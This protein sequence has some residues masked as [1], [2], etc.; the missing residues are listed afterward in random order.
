MP[1]I[2]INITDVATEAKQ[3]AQITEASTLN[4]NVGAKADAAASTDTGSFS[5]IAFIKR[6][7][8]NWTTLLGKIPNQVGGKIPVEV[9]TVTVTGGLTDAQLRATPVPVSGTVTAN[10]GLNPLTD[11][12]IRATPLPISG[13]VTA[14]TGLSQPLTDAQLRSTP[15]PISGTVT[16]NTGLTQPITDAQIRATPLPISGTVDTGLTQP[17]TNTELRAAPVDIH[18]NGAEFTFSTVNSTADN[19]AVGASFAGAVESVLTF[20]AI[21]LLFRADQT[22]I[23]TVTQYEDAGGLI[24]VNQPTQYI[25]YA[26]QPIARSFPINGNYI[27]VSVKNVGVATTTSLTLDTAYGVIDSATQLNNNSV[28]L[29]EVAGN[30]T[31]DIFRTTFSNVI[32]S[33]V[34]PS[35]FDI[36]RS[37]GTGQTVA[38]SAGNLVLT[39]G[40]TANSETILRSVRSFNGSMIARMQT[41]LSQRIAQNNF[42]FELVDVVG[43]GLTA[44][45]NSATSITVTIPNSPFT[46]A[47]VG[48]GMYLGAYSGTGTFAPQRGVIASVSGNNVTYT[49]AGMAAG[50]GTCSVFGWNY[51]QS[52]YTGITATNI[53]YGTQ[54]RGWTD[55]ASTLQINTTTTVGHMAIM[56]ND[57]GNAYF[58]D[59]LVATN[60]FIQTLNRGSR[61]MNLPEENTQLFLQIRMANGTSAPA[62]N[63]TWTVGM[64][65]V[66][67]YSPVPMTVNNI[68]PV[69]NG[70][71]L[72]ITIQNSPGILSVSL[73]S[74]PALAASTAR[75][76]FVAGS[77]IWYDDSSTNLAGAATFTG[78][79]R[80][81]TVTATATAFANAATYADELR[82]SA[83]SDVTGTLWLEV[84]RDNT[85]WR[86]VKS[87]ATA[88]VTGGGFYAEIV[89]NPSWRYA[90]VGYTN[91]AGAQARFTINSILTAI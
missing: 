83:E 10:T 73:S 7:M 23:V 11:A 68:K 44:T 74:L 6:G 4:A 18:I 32:A 24:V 46:A 12:Q 26:N 77:G 52:T 39:S 84:S 45:I 89:H 20:P 28:G 22:C 88:A 36:I 49:V 61:V 21:S 59:Q 64:A 69:G 81:L 35:F 31:R 57:D 38:Q 37:I 66:E 60:G 62:S 51:Y 25:A 75:T 63:T 71:A 27:R 87:I 8:Q 13:T 19:L 33:G 55:A 3:D 53:N 29:T 41:I 14:N 47:N 50:T 48:Q 85:N 70:S 5:I 65:S 76:G 1:D 82:V 43:D 79:S 91:G 2:N 15:V 86:R 90:R 58:Q 80:D 17:L 9:G 56:S 67:K 30:L 34:D 42:Y 40:T 78:T 72:P 54:R 16:A